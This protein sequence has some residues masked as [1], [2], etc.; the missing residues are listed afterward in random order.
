M[1]GKL[2]RI[3]DDDSIRFHMFEHPVFDLCH[4]FGKEVDIDII[5]SVNICEKKIFFEEF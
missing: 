5:I 4:L 1:F 3:G 2:E